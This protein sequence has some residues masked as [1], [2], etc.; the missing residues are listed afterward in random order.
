MVKL[1]HGCR[2]MSRRPQGQVAQGFIRRVEGLMVCTAE[3]QGGREMVERWCWS[4]AQVQVLVH[5]AWCRYKCWDECFITCTC[6]VLYIANGC[7]VHGCRLH[8]FA[9]AHGCRLM[10][11]RPG[12]QVVQGCIHWVAG[13]MVC[14]AGC[15][16]GREMVERW[17]WSWAQ[18]Q[19]L[20]HGAWCRY[21]VQIQGGE[22]Q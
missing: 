10:S 15:Q 7:I 1:A 2:L 16:G 4:W 19:V 3:C 6:F 11:R 22:R 21:M 5:G 9:L 12:G 14:T 8:M 18:V 20:V 13:L 17:C